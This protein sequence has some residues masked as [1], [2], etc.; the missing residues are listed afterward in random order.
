MV[1]QT[2]NFKLNKPEFSAT[3][4]IRLL[5]ENSDILDKAVDERAKKEEV[6]SSLQQLDTRINNLTNSIN[7]KAD[8]IS[9]DFSFLKVNGQDVWTSGS[10][11]VVSGSWVPYTE[12][13]LDVVNTANCHF[14]RHGDIVYIVFDS[15]LK[16]VS[17]SPSGNFAIKGLPYT[18]AS[19]IRFPI[20]IGRTSLR[21]YID[22][23]AVGFFVTGTQEARFANTN[24]TLIYSVLFTGATAAIELMFCGFYFTNDPV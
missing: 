1:T 19:G 16:V 18:V 3:L 13:G 11:P 20:A 6:N 15:T 10:F 2:K 21:D 8:L 14:R 4:D 12:N 23:H 9:A 22:D 5:N 7:G 24:N 17:E